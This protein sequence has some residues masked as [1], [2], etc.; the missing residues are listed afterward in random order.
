MHARRNPTSDR[1]QNREKKM[2][3]SPPSSPARSLPSSIIISQEDFS[4][5]SSPPTTTTALSKGG[6]A[7]GS[8]CCQVIIRAWRA[9]G[10][11]ESLVQAVVGNPVH[12]DIVLCSPGSAGARFCFS[13]YMNQAFEMIMMDSDRILDRSVS[14]LA[15]DVSEAELERCTRFMMSLVERKATYDY[16]DSM[17]LM[18]MAPKPFVFRHSSAHGSQ[19]FLETMVPDVDAKHP[20][21]IQKVFCS[22]SVVLMLRFALDPSGQQAA[23]LEVLQ[24]LNSKLV[25]PKQICQI[26]RVHAAARLMPNEELYALAMRSGVSSSLLPRNQQQLT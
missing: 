3:P 1:Q 7:S 26:V 23:L 19:G 4:T 13:S 17:V 2:E 6:G 10:A 9:K 22:Q 16:F 5:D 12:V 18:P 25:S 8:C 21:S 15:F 20:K 14:N 11:W 24:R